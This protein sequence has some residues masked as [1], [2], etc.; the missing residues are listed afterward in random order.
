MIHVGVG[1]RK[2][3]SNFDVIFIDE[4]DNNYG[5]IIRGYVDNN[6]INYTNI[7]NWQEASASESTGCTLDDNTIIVAYRNVNDN[8]YGTIRIIITNP[9]S[10]ANSTD[11]FIAGQDITEVSD[12]L[13]IYGHKDIA[14]SHDLFLHGYSEASGQIPLYIHGLTSFSGDVPLYLEGYQNYSGSIDL[15]IQGYDIHQDNIDLFIG[16]YNNVSGNIPLFIE[17][18]A[19]EQLISGNFDLFIGGYDVVNNNVDLFIDGYAVA[20]GDVTLY[21]NGYL[22]NSGNIPLYIDGYDYQ[23]GSIPL[24]IDGYYIISGNIPLYITGSNS[25]FS[26]I[27]LI[28]DGYFVDSNNIP[29]FIYGY[30]L[31]SGDIDLFISGNEFRDDNIDLFIYGKNT[32]NG[33]C[34]LSIHGYSD[35][36]NDTTLFI[37]GHGFVSESTPL[38]TIGSGIISYSGNIDLFINGY[39]PLEPIVCPTLDPTAT[40]QVPSSIIDIYQNRVDTLLN[41]VGKNVW[42]QFDPNISQ[43]PNCD[44]DPIRN[45]S[46]GRYKVGGPSPF[47][48]G[49]KCP[50]C[51]G[52]GVLE[53]EVGLCI[54]CLISWNPSEI[55][56][57]GISVQKDSEI[58]KIKTLIDNAANIKRARMA[59]IDRQV[60]DTVKYQAKLIKGPYPLGLREDR[61]CISFWRTI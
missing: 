51:K 8:G 60:V 36:N 39:G 56:K 45:R 12:D 21:I 4:G 54:K 55:S 48:F 29:L 37:D 15:F 5:K 35:Y 61:Y 49:R 1:L 59:I 10:F 57:F 42:L 41:K 31:H 26:N 40:I 28:I 58:V 50:Y 38:I 44:F 34:T 53:E 19:L 14:Q 27:P 20:S 7:E 32:Q 13:F 24:Y 17:A 30:N 25:S 33:S 16:G 18:A 6:N 52:R 11:L 9:P 2:N 46:S 43:C 47:I 3:N 22:Y 23:F